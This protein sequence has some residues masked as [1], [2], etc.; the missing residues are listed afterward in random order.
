M[1]DHPFSP[2]IVLI[3]FPSR[4][5]AQKI[6]TVLI[7]ERLAACVNLVSG[8]RSLFVWEGVREEADEVLA[9]VK[10]SHDQLESL[11]RRVTSLHPYR[12]PEIIA[13]PIVGGEQRYLDWIKGSVSDK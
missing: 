7:D 3:T 13:V 10:T 6:A 1:T 8:V 5:D 12:T 11:I 2:I 4:E 9:V